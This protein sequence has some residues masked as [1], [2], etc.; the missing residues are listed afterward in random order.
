[1][2]LWLRFDRHLFPQELLLTHHVD[3]SFYTGEP[4][5]EQQGSLF[6]PMMQSTMQFACLHWRPFAVC[7]SC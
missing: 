7:C 6:S 3:W 5:L 2:L 1:M 4:V